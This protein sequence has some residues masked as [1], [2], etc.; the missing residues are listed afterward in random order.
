[1]ATASQIQTK[2]NKLI[3][4]LDRLDQIVNANDSTD[5]AIDSG[6]IP[7]MAK[8]EAELAA[9]V[10]SNRIEVNGTY[11]IYVDGASGSD[12]ATGLGTGTGAFATVQ[13]AIDYVCNRLVL[14][15]AHAGAQVL[16]N[17]ASGTYAPFFLKPYVGS[18]DVGNSGFTVPT[19]QGQAGSPASV[20]ISDPGSSAAVYGVAGTGAWRIKN[21]KLQSVAGKG[22]NMDWG[23]ILYVDGTITFG[24]CPGGAIGAQWAS[25]I[26]FLANATI[27]VAGNCG[28]FASVSNFG[29]VLSQGG[30]TLTLSDTPAFSSFAFV[31]STGVVDIQGVSTINGSATGRQYTSSGGPVLSTLQIPGNKRPLLAYPYKTKFVG[32]TTFYV[33][34]STG[35][36][37]NNDG[38]AASGTAPRGPFATAQALLNYLAQIYDFSGYDAVIQFADGTT[39]PAVSL[40]TTPGGAVKFLGDVSTPASVTFTG[41]ITVYSGAQLKVAGIETSAGIT[42]NGEGAQVRVVGNC[43]FGTNAALAAQ[44][45]GKVIIE[46]DYSVVASGFFH[47]VATSGGKFSTDGAAHT[48]TITGTP[49]FSVAFAYALGLSRMTLPSLTFSGSAT[50]LRYSSNENSVIDS[51]GGGSSYLPGGTSGATATGGL[52]L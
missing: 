48:I 45:D 26:E 15:N 7:S 31:D 32:D 40:T 28:S 2:I 1:M 16:I 46:S 12:S 27:V 49:A 18:V 41:A 10:V 37:T 50:G 17:V 6:T 42:A 34:A 52:Y 29:V 51:A 19:I 8:L 24:A 25:R 33:N 4:N 14:N 36:D 22:I 38:M 21:M 3:V 11:D 43:S 20:I 9:M 23:S 47:F 5:I 35:N 44:N 13:H 30:N 39:Y